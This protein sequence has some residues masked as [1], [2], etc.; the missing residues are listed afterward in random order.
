MPPKKRSCVSS[1]ADRAKER[2]R[3]RR[4]AEVVAEKQAVASA[5]EEQRVRAEEE[6]LKFKEDIMKYP[7]DVRVEAAAYAYRCDTNKFTQ[8]ELADRHTVGQTSLKKKIKS[9]KKNDDKAH[10]DAM[11]SGVAAAGALLR[12]SVLNVEADNEAHLEYI[13]ARAEA[14]KD[15]H[16]KRKKVEELKANRTSLRAE[17]RKVFLCRCSMSQIFI[18]F[19]EKRSR[20]GDLF[21]GERIEICSKKFEHARR[22]IFCSDVWRPG[23]SFTAWSTC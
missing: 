4:E 8:S 13:S 21:C 2:D 14:A 6:R 5:I 20:Q 22:R 17:K 18:L 15:V 1:T 16:E 3:K 19:A 11:I 10:Q 12:G 23:Y 7:Y 9:L